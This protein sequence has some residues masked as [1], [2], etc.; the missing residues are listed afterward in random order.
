MNCDWAKIDL[1]RSSK[2][3]LCTCSRPGASASELRLAEAVPLDDAAQ[4]Q[5]A[6]MSHTLQQRVAQP[7]GQTAGAAAGR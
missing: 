6:A 1:S 3:G 2:V 4:G 7:A 5:G